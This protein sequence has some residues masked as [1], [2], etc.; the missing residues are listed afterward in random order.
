[1]M[2]MMM[3]MVMV[4]MIGDTDDDIIGNRDE[5]PAHNYTLQVGIYDE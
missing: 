1:M 5:L 2:V 3:M 4:M